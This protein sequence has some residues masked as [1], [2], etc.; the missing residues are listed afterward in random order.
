MTPDS[1]DDWAPPARRYAVPLTVPGW[2]WRDIWTTVSSLATGRIVRGPARARLEEAVCRRLGVEHAIAANHGRFALELALRAMGLG[3]DDE[4]VIPSFVSSSVHAAVRRAGARPVFADIDEDFHLSR[5]TVEPVLTD[6]TRCVVACHLFGRAAPVDELEPWLASL[7]IALVDDA[8]QGFGATRGGRPLGSF[9]TCG[10]L[11]T[12]PNKPLDATAGGLLVTRDAALHERA[13]AIGLEP[14]RAS[15]VARRALAGWVWYRGR[16][17]TAPFK[18]ASDRRF[19]RNEYARLTLRSM[20]NLDAAIALTRL[21]RFDRTNARRRRAL[22][23]IARGL[24]DDAASLLLRAGPTSVPFR[25]V[26]VLP[27]HGPPARE[28]LAR[29]AAAGIEGRRG[30]RPMHDEEIAL[31]VSEDGWRRV[32]V[33]SLTPRLARRRHLEALRAAVRTDDRGPGNS[34][35]PDAP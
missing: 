22:D 8:A 10:I 9:G 29:L 30:Y 6:R 11:S 28:V 23:R 27:P 26:L 15:K 7:G 32:V 25:A 20:S 12:G 35:A 13:A 34:D 16:R 17:Y 3:P 19:S 21:R 31:P 4:V 14:E 24:G 5:G 2:G 1:R 33:L 18:G